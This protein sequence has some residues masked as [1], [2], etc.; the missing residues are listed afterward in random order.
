VAWRGRWPASFTR[1]VSRPALGQL[2]G[3]WVYQ[4]RWAAVMT[5]S[6]LDG[7]G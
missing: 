5:I 3:W 1:Y 2:R 7:A 6:D 4:R